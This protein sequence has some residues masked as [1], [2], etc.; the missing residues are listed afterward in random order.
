MKVIAILLLFLAGLTG[1][2]GTNK[3]VREETRKVYK[4]GELPNANG[5]GYYEVCKREGSDER[6]RCP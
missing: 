3:E 1:C 2:P 6:F 4:V 5:V